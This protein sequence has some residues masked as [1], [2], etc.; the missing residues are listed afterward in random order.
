VHDDLQLGV[1]E[2]VV[3]K[4]TRDGL[5]EENLSK[6]TSR[7][8]SARAESDD[9]DFKGEEPART[10]SGLSS[11]PSKARKRRYAKELREAEAKAE[12]TEA[13]AEEKM[14]LDEVPEEG[15]GA[16]AAEA[17]LPAEAAAP[18]PKS[19]SRLAE[20]SIRS[21]GRSHRGQKTD[22][23][24]EQQKQRVYEEQAKKKAS[25]LKFDDEPTPTAKGEGVLR[26][27][28]NAG[29]TVAGKAGLVA[30]T[31]AHVKV[32]E[33]EQDNSAVEAAHKTE[34]VA[35]G[36][37]RKTGQKLSESSRTEKTH[38]RN[39]SSSLTHEAEKPTSK[40]HFEQSEPESSVQKANVRKTQQKKQIKRQYAEGVRSAKKAG[41]NV[42]AASAAPKRSI[43]ERI[44]TGVKKITKN[45]KGAVIAAA[46][47]VLAVIL[48][49]SAI[50]SV[51]LP[52]KES[53]YEL[54]RQYSSKS[55]HLDFS[56]EE[57]NEIVEKTDGFSHS[58]IEAMVK[59]V[60][61]TKLLYDDK[62]DV[63][64]ELIHCADKIIPIS[65]VNK[66]LVNEIIE[67]G[68]DRTLSV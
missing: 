51:G 48:I 44:S 34:M 60:A 52:D 43:K 63:I 42:S 20:S 2:K 65:K 19:R 29:K 54:I 56:E 28:G 6:G 17:E 47:G 59:E 57:I 3:Q 58:D 41:E 36:A 67:W 40:L 15:S 31:A 50:G 18:K 7:K 38:P 24:H 66:E 14:P 45:N 16:E 35:E 33:A 27:A 21:E 10:S 68:K 53:R 39:R 22:A 4:M 62:I 26:K 30:G 25:K 55:L 5:V 11:S 46:G 64:G 23:K 12:G 8:V 13:V 49:I 37:V 1:K 9:F 32:S 61:Q